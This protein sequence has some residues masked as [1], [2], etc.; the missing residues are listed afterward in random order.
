MGSLEKSRRVFSEIE[1]LTTESVHPDS[2]ELDRFSVERIL[3]LMSREDQ[4]VAPAVRSVLPQIEKA[5]EKVI[6]SF[7]DD[8]RLIYI[9]AGT[10]GR[11]GIIDAAE[12]PP[13]FGSDPRQVVGIIA[14]GRE[15][16]FLSREGAEDDA[17][18]GAR[19]LQEIGV[20]PEDTVVGIATSSRTPYVLGALKYARRKGAGTV[21]VCCN[22]AK[23]AARAGAVADVIIAPVLGPEI[24]MG[25][26]R[27][28]AGT[29]TK[30]ILN[31]ISTAAFIRSGKVY[32]GMMVD[33]RAWSEKLKARSRRV[34]MLATGLDYDQAG[35]IL[36]QADGRVK[37]AVV[38]ALCGVDRKKANELLEDADG[39]VREAIKRHGSP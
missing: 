22:P 4:K 14:G 32:R 39:F 20:K 37:T 10:S 18:G 3:E 35:D 2:E 12:C 16:V 27:L 24:I 7:R 8:G 23:E 25:S 6:E 5:V 17:E 13:T 26:T 30:M 36:K 34:L 9:G 15:S 31:M 19:D 11:L 28:K 29:A 1:G 33:L 38:M 21:F